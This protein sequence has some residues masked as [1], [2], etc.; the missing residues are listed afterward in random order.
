MQT[1]HLAQCGAAKALPQTGL[2]VSLSHT[3]HEEIEDDQED[4][5]ELH[6]DTLSP[7]N[8]SS[9][10]ENKPPSLGER[11]RKDIRRGPAQLPRPSSGLFFF[12]LFTHASA[13]RGAFPCAEASLRLL[14]PIKA[15]PADRT[16]WIVVVLVSIMS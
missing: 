13:W 3:L 5:E 11:R 9:N 14:K 15:P 16:V 8:S 2:R 4:T 10:S 6:F 12:S 7:R 1:E